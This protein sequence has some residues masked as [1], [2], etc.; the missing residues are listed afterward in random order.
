MQACD[1]GRPLYELQ[2]KRGRRPSSNPVNKH[3][4]RKTSSLLLAWRLWSEWILFCTFWQNTAR[5]SRTKKQEI[6]TQELKKLRLWQSLSLCSSHVG[7]ITIVRSMMPGP[8]SVAVKSSTARTVM[9]GHLRFVRWE[10]KGMARLPHTPN[11]TS[12]MASSSWRVLGTAN[13]IGWISTHVK[14]QA[15]SSVQEVQGILRNEERKL[16][17]ESNEVMLTRKWISEK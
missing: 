3:T 6:C 16:V 12:T 1:K 5:E 11:N 13:M 14:H 17:I 15:N 8:S 4:T 10:T 7:L 2:P 9:W